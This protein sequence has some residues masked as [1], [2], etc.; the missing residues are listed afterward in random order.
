M[1]NQA[2]KLTNLILW[3]K[4]VMFTDIIIIRVGRLYKNI[5][6]RSHKFMQISHQF[7]KTYNSNELP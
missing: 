2:I 1:V 4:M 5:R 3:G 7:A 6:M